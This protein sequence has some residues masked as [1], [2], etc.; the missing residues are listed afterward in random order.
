MPGIPFSKTH[1]LLHA[2]LCG[3]PDFSRD[4]R[5]YRNLNP[6]RHRAGLITWEA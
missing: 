1:I 3:I 6:L 5:G 2:G 4:E